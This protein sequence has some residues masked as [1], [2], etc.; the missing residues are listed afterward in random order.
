VELFADNLDLDFGGFLRIAVDDSDSIVQRFAVNGLAEEGASVDL[1]GRYVQF[2]VA[3]DD[4]DLRAAAAAALGSYILDGELEELDAAMA[5][6]AEQAL[7]AVLTDPQ[8]PAHVQAPALESIA[9]SGELGVRQLIEDAYYS[10]D[11]IRRLSALV[12]MGR[13]A[14]VRWRRMVR[15]ELTN[16]DPAMRAQAAY[17]CGEL[18][19]KSALSDLLKL[20]S[21]REQQ[22]RLAAMFALS[23]I[24]GPQARNAL[25]SVQATGD[26]VEAFAAEQALEEMDFYA[27]VEAASTPL[28]DETADESDD[29]DLDDRPDWDDDGQD[30]DLGQYE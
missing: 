19:A 22:V 20:L 29:D 7:M 8:A 1:L 24:G 15:A 17:A 14:D 21:D 26:E 18:E 3:A 11:E 27:G 6:R 25:Q 28:Y 23:H 12:A 5:M 2:L 4:M 13:S 16:P 30:D 9:Y 10:P